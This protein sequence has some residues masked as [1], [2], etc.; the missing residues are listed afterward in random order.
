MLI[1]LIRTLTCIMFCLP[2]IEEHHL[3]KVFP[4]L[5]TVLSITISIANV[6]S[7]AYVTS[8]VS[9]ISTIV[10]RAKRNESIPTMVVASKLTKVVLTSV[11]SS[12]LNY[13]AKYSRSILNRDLDPR[14]RTSKFSKEPDQTTSTT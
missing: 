6:L 3:A 5:V 9:F 12:S 14:V 1:P 13:V 8:I 2:A 10:V 4:N 7:I 11:Y